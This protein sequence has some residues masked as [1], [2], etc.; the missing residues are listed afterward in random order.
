AQPRG[1]VAP[2]PAPGG[3]ALRRGTPDEDPR[4]ERLGGVMPRGRR[5]PRGARQAARDGAGRDRPERRLARGDRARAGL[6]HRGGDRRL[7]SAHGLRA[8]GGRGRGGLRARDQQRTGQPRGFQVHAAG[9]PGAPRGDGRVHDRLG[10]GAAAR[11]H[12][13]GHREGRRGADRP[14]RGPLEEARRAGGRPDR[15]GDT[16]PAGADP[17]RRRGL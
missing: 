3:R 16:A 2:V 8:H 9:A 5:A 12:L 10:G 13:S 6:R 14:R 4:A 11:A 1:D 15:A 17:P 7:L